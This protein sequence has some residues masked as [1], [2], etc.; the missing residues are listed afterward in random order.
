MV[1]I[2]NLASFPCSLVYLQYSAILSNEILL[3]FPLP[4]NP[5]TRHARIQRSTKLTCSS[6]EI[7]I[8]LKNCFC[9]SIL[10]IIKLLHRSHHFSPSIAQKSPLFEFLCTEVVY[11]ILTITYLLNLWLGILPRQKY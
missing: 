9:L 4:C 3:I 10:I 2:P 6:S 8:D 7:F 1:L 5:L 11:T